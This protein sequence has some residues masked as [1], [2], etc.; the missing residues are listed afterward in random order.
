[1]LFFSD[2]FEFNSQDLNDFNVEFNISN[3]CL[4]LDNMNYGVKFKCLDISG[5]I[6]LQQTF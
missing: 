5:K 4:E 1:M 3:G 2:V 6:I